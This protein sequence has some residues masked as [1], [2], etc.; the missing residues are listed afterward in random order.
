MACVKADRQTHRVKAV[1]RMFRSST[2]GVFLC[3]LMDRWEIDRANEIYVSPSQ[4]R[5]GVNKD[6]TRAG[7]CLA[8]KLSVQYVDEY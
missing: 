1:R 4:K 3:V 5:G 6:S 8:H 2:V 7:Y